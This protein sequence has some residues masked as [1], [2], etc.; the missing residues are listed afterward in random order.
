[1]VYG[2]IALGPQESF[3]KLNQGKY[4]VNMC[5]KSWHPY[6]DINIVHE[7]GLKDIQCK[8]TCLI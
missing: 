4:L 1:M 8:V 7:I 6:S 3:I 5:M 2:I